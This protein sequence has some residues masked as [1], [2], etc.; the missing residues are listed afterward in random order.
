MTACLFSEVWGYKKIDLLKN[1]N[2]NIRVIKGAGSVY[3]SVVMAMKIE[4]L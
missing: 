1:L 2:K 4:L 3:T